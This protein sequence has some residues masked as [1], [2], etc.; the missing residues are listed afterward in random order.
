MSAEN[1]QVTFAV[2]AHGLTGPVGRPVLIVC[3]A[4]DRR[5]QQLL[6]IRC[7]PHVA[8]ECNRLNVADGPLSRHELEVIEQ[9]T[10]AEL[11][12]SL[13]FW[14]GVQAEFEAPPGA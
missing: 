5:P 7:A 12:T 6:W 14:K 4:L 13:L 8:T 9:I 1:T 11:Y 10:Y 3:E 2:Q